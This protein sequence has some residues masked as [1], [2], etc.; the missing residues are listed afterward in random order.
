ME[1]KNSLINTFWGFLKLSQLTGHFPF[2]KSIDEAT[3]FEVVQPLGS[4]IWFFAF[5]L[6]HS[7]LF[8]F[9]AIG[10]YIS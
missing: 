3:K 8:G 9:I 7:A 2:K 1:V 5:L 4:C 6:S 10:I